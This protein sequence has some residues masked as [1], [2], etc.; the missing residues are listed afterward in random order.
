MTVRK[1][2]E[3]FK[4]EMA[5]K[6][7]LIA[8]LTP[9]T[10]STHKMTYKCKV[11]DNE[12]KAEARTVLRGASG[13]PKCAKNR[14]IDNLKKVGEN[15]PVRVSK[16]AF[17]MGLRY[18]NPNVTLV[19]DFTAICN[20]HHFKCSECNHLWRARA[21]KLMRG[22]SSCPVCS[23]RKRKKTHEQ[24][25]LEISERNPRIEPVTQY[26]DSHD[27]MTF[28]CL[29]CKNE[30]TTSASHIIHSGSGGPECA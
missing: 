24:F 12:W 16:D 3:Q 23:L 1:T 28:R 7:P 13:C 21:N 26:K 19:D 8:V 22:Y 5:I 2:P 17:L 9:Y 25:L 4:N 29:D 15:G 18:N 6:Q 27:P 14:V 11:C 20:Y 30:W 10:H